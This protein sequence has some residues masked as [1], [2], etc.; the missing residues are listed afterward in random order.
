MEDRDMDDSD[1]PELAGAAA[2]RLCNVGLFIELGTQER[3]EI[4]RL[5][6]GAGALSQQIKV[7][8]VRWR[9]ELGIDAATEVV[10]VVLLYRHGEPPT[11]P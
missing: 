1:Q 4:T 8:I 5:K 9:E 11:S 3:T 6:E 2:A 10:P 7:A